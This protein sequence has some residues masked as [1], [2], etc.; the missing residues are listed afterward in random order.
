MT[1]NI[2]IVTALKKELNIIKGN[3]FIK[4]LIDKK[5]VKTTISGIGELTSN[6]IKENKDFLRKF[7]LIINCGVCGSVN[8]DIKLFETV[9]PTK[10]IFENKE[11][12]F[13]KGKYSIATVKKP[14]F[15]KTEKLQ[16]NAHLIDMESYYFAE[17]CKQNNINF[18]AVKTVSDTLNTSE[19]KFAHLQNLNQALDFLKK[20]TDKLL[21]HIK[22]QS[23][24]W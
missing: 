5:I 24:L 4:Q 22:E 14:I 16:I 20:E 13:E 15:E 6:F 8:P 2:L 18:K 10:F 23:D 11:I 3:A 12:V 1:A 9:F 19:E 7:G 17:F 21:Q